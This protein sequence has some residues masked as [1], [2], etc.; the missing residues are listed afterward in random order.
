MKPGKIHEVFQAEG[1]SCNS[2]EDNKEARQVRFDTDSRSL[3]I[4]NH[5]SKC[6]SAYIDDF[7]DVPRP[8]RQVVAGIG[9]KISNNMEGTIE[10]AIE[11]DEGRAH[12]IRVPNAIYSPD[13][14]TRILSLQQWS[15]S[16]KDNHPMKRGTWAGTYDD[17]IE[18]WWDQC[19]YKRTVKLNPNESNVGIIQTAPGY[20]RY[21]AFAA[22]IGE[23]EGGEFDEDMIHEPAV[24]SEDEDD[25][26]AEGDFNEP[27]NAEFDLNGPDS[28]KE[29]EQIDI[30]EEDNIPPSASAEFL[31]WHHRLGHMAPKKIKLMAKLGVLPKRLSNCPIPICTSC[32]FGK[33]SRRPWRY[34]TRKIQKEEVEELTEPGQCVS[35][36]QMESTT[37]G[38]IAQLKGTPT[39]LR[40]RAA[41]VFVDQ[42]SGLSFVYLQK[43]LSSEETVEAKHACEQYF[44]D[45]GVKIRHY[46]ADNG[47]FA[48]NLWRQDCQKQRQ[49]LTFCGVNAHFQNGIAERRIRELQEQT[50]TAL[51]HANRRWP[52]V[53][54]AH[55]WPY[56]L[57]M[58]N[59]LL[60]HS[61]DLQR[62]HIPIEAFSGTKVRFNPNHWAHFGCPVYVLDKDLQ[63]PGKKIGK[64]EYRARVGCYLGQSPQHARTVA[65]V[66]SL[67][68]GL[69]SPQFHVTL[70]PTFQTMRR[71]FGATPLQSKWM[72]KCHFVKDV[73]EQTS[74]DKSSDK[75]KSSETAVTNEQGSAKRQAR[76]ATE[77]RRQKRARITEQASTE[78]NSGPLDGWPPRERLRN[79]LAKSIPEDRKSSNATQAERVR[80]DLAHPSSA[81]SATQ[82][83]E[84][85]NELSTEGGKNPMTPRST[86]YQEDTQQLTPRHLIEVMM[87]EI[88]SG[89]SE[90]DVPFEAMRMPK[91]YVE[92]DHPLQA[93]KA[94]TDPD[95]MYFH[96]ALKQ[97]DRKEFI[98]AMDKELTDQ[99][100]HGNFTVVH[101]DTVPEDATVLP[102]VWA[103]R[104]KRRQDTGEI[105]KYKGRLNVDGSKQ[106]KG[107]NYWETF[108]PVVTWPAIR[109]V[110]AL[111]L[112][113]NWK[114]RQI[115]YVQAY[116]QADA[117]L[118]DLY[119]K[120]PK[121]VDIEEGERQDYLLKV[122]K[123]VYG[124]HDAG[125][126]WNKFL[127]GKLQIAG[128]EQ[129]KVDE[130]VFYRGKCIY[131]LYTDDSILVGPTDEELDEAVEA[132][133]A[134]G[135]KLTVEGTIDDFIG[136][137]IERRADGTYNLTQKHLIDQILKDM[138]LHS[139]NVKEKQ[140]PAMISKNLT[141]HPE[142]ASFDGHFNYRSIIGKLNFLASSTR[143]DI[144]HA[145]HSAA[146]FQSDPK[147]EH[148]KA[149]E[150][151]CRYLA[152]T[153]D[154]GMIFDPSADHSFDVYCDADFAGN[155]DPEDT[156]NPDTARSRSAYVIMYAGCP[157]LWAS[158][159]QTLFALSSTE[160]E[161]YSLS[162]ALRQTIPIMELAKEMKN[163]GFNIGSTQPRVHCKVF[164]D[165]SG[166][167]EMATI[168]K[169]RPRTKHMN[170]QVHHF[171]HHVN[172]GEI[173]IHPISTDDQPAD[174]LSKSVAIAKLVK[175]RKFIMGW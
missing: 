156:D 7:I 85:G 11:D 34:K 87:S 48:D 94:T 103:L 136:V 140:T 47:R 106:Q 37:P 74:E 135:L 33:A 17:C 89:E 3:R 32:I 68:T 46:H 154:K 49:R 100:N 19:K 150:W 96:E 14:G 78:P 99:M 170:C 91:M 18:M 116:P 118:D 164:E 63:Q 120:I 23:S 112:I 155:W 51:I 28:S 31:K 81:E 16:A 64:W 162:T 152:G 40:Y 119:V 158:K 38:L 151:L 44:A 166:A 10:F 57:R 122:N 29:E 145:T 95:T 163:K 105:Y 65:L 109:F 8:T 72:A 137:N 113:N 131:T 55:L 133:K 21:H 128:F 77:S 42:F 69:V 171:R 157:I 36:D 67:Q 167:L 54:N 15:Q 43:T 97:P 125:R 172:T 39:K 114:S 60:N 132:M 50:R 70:D 2:G 93:F 59:D 107:I 127:V 134:T 80:Q 175:F 35:V 6:I 30:E 82:V 149:V 130:C 108:A 84:G 71:S 169:T 75:P 142:S 168:H 88:G 173:T 143:P 104:R 139:S 79:G 26:E 12:K 159:L 86:E 13:S 123:N 160:S 92:E 141:R 83:A 27:T 138:R 41:S 161:Y 165:N 121:G 148:G 73:E 24:V 111:T 61:P 20:A 153:R 52:E 4:D 66:L 22:E 56:A 1:D 102:T 146:R 129:S 90:S 144:A 45:H 124:T 62:K 9:G 25:W 53:V 117:P 174:M 76:E 110:L 101:K 5:A 126:V 147:Q 115:D 58:A 98:K